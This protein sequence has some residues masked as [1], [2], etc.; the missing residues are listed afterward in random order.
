MRTDL[1]AGYES[2]VKVRLL[3][4]ASAQREIPISIA[5]NADLAKYKDIFI[6][7]VLDCIRVDKPFRSLVVSQLQLNQI[8]ASAS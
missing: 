5:V 2:F 4:E 6:V 8:G 1:S 3:Y 7:S